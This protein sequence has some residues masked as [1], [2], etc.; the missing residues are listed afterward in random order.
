MRLPSLLEISLKQLAPACVVITSKTATAT[1]TAIATGD[2][3]RM[4]TSG[5]GDLDDW[6]W[7]GG[8]RTTNGLD[9]GLSHE[10]VGRADAGAAPAGKIFHSRVSAASAAGRNTQFDV[11]I[12][13][14]R[15]TS[16]HTGSDLPL[17]NRIAYAN[18]HENNY[19]K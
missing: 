7:V 13:E 16:I 15:C 4:R 17:G 8:G 14:G 11:Q 5:S 18:V 3:F 10:F 1:A 9:E 12:V 6:V 2:Q 19:R